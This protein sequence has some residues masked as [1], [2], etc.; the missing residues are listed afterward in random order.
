MIDVFN[1]LMLWVTETVVDG[2][3]IAFQLSERQQSLVNMAVYFIQLV[4]GVKRDRDLGTTFK[5]GET[6]I[7]IT[8]LQRKI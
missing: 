6:N 5:S 2:K 4:S 8:K 7:K 1:L 3:C